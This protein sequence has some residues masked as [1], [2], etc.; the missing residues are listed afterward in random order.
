MQAHGFTSALALRMET[1]APSTLPEW[2]ETSVSD[3]T[4]WT[5]ETETVLPDFSLDSSVFR[6]R[7]LKELTLV[8]G[9]G[10]ERKDRL[11]KKQ[12]HTISDLGKTVWKH[13]AEEVLEIVCNGPEQEIIRLFRERGRGADPL[14]TGLGC[15]CQK[16]DLLFYDIETLGMTHSPIIL[17]GCGICR[18]NRLVTTQYLLRNIS[19]EIAVLARIADLFRRHPVPVTYNGRTFDIPYTNSRLCF[20]GERELATEFQVD[21]LH[22]SR[23]LFGKEL[24]DCRLGTVEEGILGIPRSRDLPGYLVPVYYRKY[25]E[26]LDPKPLERIVTHNRNDVTSLAL[27]LAKQKEIMYGS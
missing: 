7:L 17:F 12:I 23:R 14:L 20:Y 4:C 15:S 16:E 13:A 10:P 18:G 3:G 27:L 6:E 1:F 25:L 24:P 26:T 9:I 11:E 21:L 19:E 5:F 2:Y 22:P 8:K